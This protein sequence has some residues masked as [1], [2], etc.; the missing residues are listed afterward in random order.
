MHIALKKIDMEA[1]TRLAR[2]R[3]FELKTLHWSGGCSELKG[4]LLRYRSINN[5]EPCISMK[6]IQKIGLLNRNTVG[7]DPNCK[8]ANILVTTTA[9]M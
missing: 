5:N 9:K 6:D 1:A 3:K 7:K 4:L 8:E 2:F